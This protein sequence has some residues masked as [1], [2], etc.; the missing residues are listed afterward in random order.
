M[1][2][3]IINPFTGQLDADASSSTGI[4]PPSKGGTGVAN[5]TAHTLPVAEGSSPF[6]FLGPLTNGQM[7]IGSTGVDPVPAT[8]S[9]GNNITWTTGAGTLTGNVTGTTNH[10]VQVGNTGGSLTSLSAATN[11]QVLIGSTGADPVFA[12]ITS[13]GGTIAV[14]LGAGTVNLESTSGGFKWN[15]IAGT[16]QSI[17]AENGYINSNVG[18]TTLTLPLT[19]SVGY[20]F[21]IAGYGAG[22]WRIAQNAGQNIYLG[23]STTS[24]GVGGSLSSTNAHDSIEVMCVIANTEWQALDFI[25]NITVV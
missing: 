5:P 11:G 25:G 13:S 23:S 18:L 19:G 1:P 2:H 9:N 3:F 14:T 12:A 4:I 15:T 8:L 16:S 7:L 24:V 20:T 21:K 17:T 6:N 22:G 10:T